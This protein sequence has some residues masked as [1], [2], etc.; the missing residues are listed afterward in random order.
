MIDETA[1]TYRHTQWAPWHLMLDAIGVALL[2][3]AWLSSE[4]P[5]ARW[6]FVGLA[7]LFLLLGASFRHLVVEDRGEHL[8][9]HFGPLP[10]FRRRIRCEAVRDVAVDRTTLLE[11][12]GIHMSPRGGWVWN[13]WGRDCVVIHLERGTLRLGTDDAANLEAFLRRMVG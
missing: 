2:V 9:I 7:T 11:S 13:I 4:P 10:L 8:D 3:A 5:F 12:W 1:T 6:V